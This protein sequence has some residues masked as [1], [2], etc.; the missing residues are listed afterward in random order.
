MLGFD[1]LGSFEKEAEGG[2]TPE[3]KNDPGSL[4]TSQRR[5]WKEWSYEFYQRKEQ[6][7]R[8]EKETIDRDKTAI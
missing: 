7:H 5:H 1:A 4:S 8:K 6:D 2:S 3:A